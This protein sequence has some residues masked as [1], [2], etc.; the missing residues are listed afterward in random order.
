MLNRKKLLLLI[1]LACST[2]PQALAHHGL[3]FL[4]VQDAYVPTPGD[5][6]LY[7]GFDWARKSSDDFF[8]TEPG[9]VIGLLPGLSFGIGTEISDDGNGWNA[10]SLSPYFQAQILPQAW[11]QRVRIALRVGYDFSLTPYESTAIVPVTITRKVTKPGRTTVVK[12]TSTAGGGATPPDPCTGPD[13]GKYT[14]KHAGHTAT[15]THTTVVTGKPI[16]TNET[17]TVFKEVR[18]LDRIEGIS[19]RLIVE[20]DLTRSDRL[21]LNLTHFSPSHGPAQL[22]YAAGLRHAFNH[23]FAMS[24]EALGSFDDD[25]WHEAVLAAH[26]GLTHHLLVKFGA[27]VGLTKDTPDFS[28][29]TGFVLRF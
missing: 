1:T 13:C 20:T 11:S 21:V 16:V 12:T 4:L 8:S 23:D 25:N 7:G 24:V 26:F 15:T 5:L 27:S 17:I 29:H 28:L 19:S 18:T 22:G 14:P 3:D 6:T 2:V 9:V 10:Y